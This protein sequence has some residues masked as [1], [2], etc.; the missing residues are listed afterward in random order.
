MPNLR[1]IYD[2]AADRATL[3]ASSSADA[4]T[5]DR[6][7]TDIKSD[8]WRSTGTTATITAT[9]QV[10]E[11]IGGVVLPFCNL[12]P[13]ATLRVR[14]YAS[15]GDGVPSFDTGV[16]EACPAP[17]LGLWDW[18]AVPLGSNAYTFGGGTYARAWMPVPGMVEKLVVDIVDDTNP[19]GYIEAARLVCGAYW[20]PRI[21]AEFGAPV[22]AV[23]MSKHVRTDAGDLVTDVGTRHKTQ[24]VSLAALSP[25]D[26]AT[27]WSIVW[28]NGMCRPLFFSLYPDSDDA[29]LEQTH[30]LYGKLSSTAAMNTPLFQQYA[31]TLDIEEI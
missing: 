8:V 6:L 24:S 19:A 30:Q 27:L 16:V 11:A 29:R 13:R 15:A 22:Q 26:R 25:V 20:E 18:G 21:N 23:D 12:T 4:M 10:A 1:I 17:V 28:G 2:N 9:W 31:T 3:T 7:L 14:G 5:A